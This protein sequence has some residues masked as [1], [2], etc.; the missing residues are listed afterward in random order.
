MGKVEFIMGFVGRMFFFIY[1][2][3]GRFS[4]EDI[5]KLI[6]YEGWVIDGY[7]VEI[8]RGNSRCESLE[9]VRMYGY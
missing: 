1:R 6:L 8:S 9:L 4:Y 2:G 5:F 7:R 3:G